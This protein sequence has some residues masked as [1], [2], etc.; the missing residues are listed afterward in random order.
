VAGVPLTAAVALLLFAHQGCG[1]TESLDGYGGGVLDPGDAST[2]GYAGSA[3]D[4]SAPDTAGSGGDASIDA[5][6]AG[7]APDGQHADAAQD[8]DGDAP[9][10]QD[11]DAAQDAE[12]ATDAPD[13]APPCGT[14]QKL[15]G[16]TCV[17]VDDPAYGCGTTGCTPCPDYPQMTN[18]C[19]GTTCSAECSPG[20][21]DCNDST[22]D[23]CE[24]DT[25]TDIQHCGACGRACSS[26]HVA[27]ALSCT[28]GLCDTTECAGNWSNVTMP[29]APDPD[30]GCEQSD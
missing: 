7:D 3:G 11:A 2:A 14:G 27:G 16:G 18:V 5:P 30:D 9:D 25:L 28:N 23:G 21:S 24:S 20:W 19:A 12:A 22:S 6:E 17:D 1:L 10:G 15:C 4:A 13:D 8:A 29:P 26:S